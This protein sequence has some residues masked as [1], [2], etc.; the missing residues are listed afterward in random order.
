MLNTLRRVLGTVKHTA[1][2]PLD[3]AIPSVGD[4][5]LRRVEALE[6]AETVRAAEHAAMVDQ[7][8][9]LYKRI[10][11]RIAR[12]HSAKP[13]PASEGESV[14]SLRNRLQR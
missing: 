9:R 10:T 11:A 3:G 8:D 1:P 5:L 4:P 7:L 12:E 14:L 13:E 6:R 2:A